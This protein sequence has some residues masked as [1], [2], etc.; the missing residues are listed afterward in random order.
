[1]SLFS[2]RVSFERINKRTK[3]MFYGMLNSSPKSIV[4]HSL[5][6]SPK[7]AADTL[8]QMNY[9]YLVRDITKIIHPIATN[10]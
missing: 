6:K 3:K 9:L 2:T 1:M 10:N 7:Y 4:K 8:T 5:D